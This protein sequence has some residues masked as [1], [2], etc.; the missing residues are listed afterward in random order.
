VTPNSMPLEAVLGY[1][2]NSD[3]DTLLEALQRRSLNP[4][5]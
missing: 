5:L 3:Q 4:P 2:S 1:V